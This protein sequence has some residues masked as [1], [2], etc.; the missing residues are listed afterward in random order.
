[1]EVTYDYLKTAFQRLKEHVRQQPSVFFF[2]LVLLVIPM[3]YAVNSVALML[4]VGYSLICF[5]ASRFA[6]QPH[7]VLPVLLFGL[8]SLSLIWTED[9]AFSIKA[10]QKSLPLLLLPLSMMSFRAWNAMQKN[11]VV[12][13]FSIGILCFVLYWLL[14]ATIRYWQGYDKDV[15]FYHELVTEDVNAIHVA[16]YVGLAAFYFLSKSV[17]S[18]WD[19]GAFLLLSLFLILLSSKNIFILFV[20]LVIW[21]VY[22]QFKLSAKGKWLIAIGLTAILGGVAFTG[23]IKER[24]AEELSSSHSLNETL[25]NTSGPVYNVGIQQAW[26]QEKFQANDYFPGTAFRV[27]QAH[28]FCEM[29]QEDAILLT[30]YGLNAADEKIRQKGAQHQVY[31]GGPQGAGY[32]EKNF[33]NQYIQL[34]AELGIFGLFILLVMLAVNLKN[35]LKSKDFVHISFAILMIS[36][37]LTES[38]LSRQRGL[39]FF[40]AFYCV[41]NAKLEFGRAK[42]AKTL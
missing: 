16:V 31:S 41:M 10:L 27:Y 24:F 13:G 26:L 40:T 1:M 7:L 20:L 14:R 19:Y 34:F 36:L 42:T 12:K 6:W 8:M 38:F 30:G 17:K 29:L 11:T 37:F 18:K 25:S 35:A 32:Q 28:I 15:F 33:H 3:G 4:L 22:R 21:W 39:I 5:K 9:W 2:L 23:K